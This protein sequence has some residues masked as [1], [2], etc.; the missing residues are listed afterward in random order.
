MRKSDAERTLART[1]ELF[2][3]KDFAKAETACRNVL[4]HYPRHATALSMLGANLAG[5]GNADKAIKAYQKALE[6][7]PDQTATLNNLGNLLVRLKRHDEAIRTLQQLVEARP[8]EV[9][10][11]ASLSSALFHN[12][13]LVEAA[14]VARQAIEVDPA[15]SSGHKHLGRALY[16]QGFI[17]PAVDAYQKAIELDPKDA[18][19]FDAMLATMHFSS[20]YSAAE[21]AEQHREWDRRY[22][23]KLL[24]KRLQVPADDAEGRRLRVGFV[25]PDLHRHPVSYFLESLFEARDPE[26]WDIICYADVYKPDELTEKLKGLSTQW[27]SSHKLSNEALAKQI[28]KDKIDILIDLVGHTSKNRLLMLARKPA[29]VQATW[30][31]YFNA[32]GLS[33]IDYLICD[34][35]GVPDDAAE[36]YVETPLR[37]PDGFTVYTAPDWAPQVAPLPALTNG[38]VTFGSFNQITKITE[39]VVALWSQLLKRMPTARLVMRTKALKDVDTCERYRAWFIANDVNP[40]RIDLL[41]PTSQ[42]GMLQT[43]GKVDIALDP[44]PVAGGTTTCESLW[45]GV[46]AVTYAGDRYAG[47]MSAS[48]MI[49]AGLPQF[50]TDDLSAYVSVAEA[51]TSDIGK[52][53]ELRASLR[54]NLLRSPMIDARRFADNF[55]AALRQMWRYRDP[56]T[57]PRLVDVPQTAEPIAAAQ[58]A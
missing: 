56:A 19:S 23:R 41:P 43:Y 27:R 46:P 52:L 42:M 12:N 54:D 6:I 36:L 40:N 45:M 28:R 20:R 49:N 58:D 44:F 5:Q 29:P 13:D 34:R 30:L 53:A 21:I 57:R 16:R 48:Y 10:G 22:A 9:M 3:R 47:R 4:R 35:I 2:R 14:N 17:E 50:V 33:A 1:R 31:G 24:P 38:Y 32:T 51:V 11:Y 26:D 39:E 55:S 7:E 25:S 8:N 18:D 37:M 15:N